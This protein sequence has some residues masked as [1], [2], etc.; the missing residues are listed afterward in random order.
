MACK[1]TLPRSGARKLK[2]SSSTCPGTGSRLKAGAAGKANS[3]GVGVRDRERPLPLPLRTSSDSR[4]API[5]LPDSNAY[6]SQNLPFASV[7]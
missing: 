3:A 7:R 2:T 6:V 4:K 1:K 5:R